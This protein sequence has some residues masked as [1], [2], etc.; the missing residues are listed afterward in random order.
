MLH[1]HAG[2]PTPMRPC[3]MAM[4]AAGTNAPMLHGHAG[5][6]TPTRPCCMA[7]LAAR[8]NA[9][10][11]HGH[12]GRPTPTRPCLTVAAAEAGACSRRQWR[13]S[14]RARGRCTVRWRPACVNGQ[15]AGCPGARRAGAWRGAEER[16]GR[17]RGA[18][19]K[20][21]ERGPRSALA[22]TGKRIQQQQL[23]SYQIE[24]ARQR[25]GR[26]RG[27][28][29]LLSAEVDTDMPRANVWMCC[30]TFAVVFVGKG[31]QIESMLTDKDQRRVVLKL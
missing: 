31:C 11:L 13:R 2:R 29:A 14:S 24:I 6:P 21:V 8:T 3:C 9:P 22:L 5:R 25:P 19:G 26:A 12:A 1:G 20:G 4:L 18:E 16:R 30:C 27:Y 15:K 28:S 10:M 17:Q 7:M 23:K